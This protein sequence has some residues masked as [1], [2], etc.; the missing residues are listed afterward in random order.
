MRMNEL[1]ARCKEVWLNRYAEYY[2]FRQ[3]FGMAD[4]D[5]KMTAHDLYVTEDAIRAI[6]GGMLSDADFE[7]WEA[8]LYENS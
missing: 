7:K 4:E 3:S 2:E 5:T 1:K 8:E 6:T